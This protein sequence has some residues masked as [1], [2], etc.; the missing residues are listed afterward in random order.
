MLSK[1]RRR[2]NRQ[3]RRVRLVEMGE[4]FV[5]LAVEGPVSGHDIERCSSRSTLLPTGKEGG[6]HNVHTRGFGSGRTGS[7][8][9][10]IGDV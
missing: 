3:S 2:L 8:L 6:V 4:H 5:G 9:G 1:A 7:G 10:R